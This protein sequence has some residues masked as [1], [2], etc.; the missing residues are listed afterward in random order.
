ML[1]CEHAL[2]CHVAGEQGEAE[3]QHQES[4][5][6]LDPAH[7]QVARSLAGCSKTPRQSLR[8]NGQGCER[9]NG[10]RGAEP[11]DEGRDHTGPEQALRKCI[12]QN[13]DRPRAGPQ[14]DCKNRRQAALPSAGTGK[15]RRLGPMRVPAMLIVDVIIAMRM[16]V[17]MMAMVVVMM[18]MRVVMMS[19]RMAMMRVC[20]G[21]CLGMRVRVRVVMSVRVAMMMLGFDAVPGGDKSTALHP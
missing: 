19:V 16:I 9:G 8:M 1:L 10:D 12:N 6:D 3:N 15:L 18:I 5:C 17:I 14:A 20:M 13:Q 21:V 2:A 4:G 7:D 11:H